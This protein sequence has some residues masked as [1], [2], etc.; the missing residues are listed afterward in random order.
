VPAGNTFFNSKM[1]SSGSK[2]NFFSASLRSLD[3]YSEQL[4]V[5]GAERLEARGGLRDCSFRFRS[6]KPVFSR[7]ALTGFVGLLSCTSALSRS[8]KSQF[9]RAFA[10]AFFLQ[11]SRARLQ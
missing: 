3:D 4:L 9:E 5:I 1:R 7:S 6:L 8:K 2:A 10:G 11:V